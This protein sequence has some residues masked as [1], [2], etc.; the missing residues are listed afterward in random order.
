MRDEQDRLSRARGE[1]ES[2]LGARQRFVGTYRGHLRNLEQVANDLLSAYRSANIETREDP[3]PRHFGDRWRID[4][5]PTPVFTDTDVEAVN[6]AVERAKAS[7][8]HQVRKVAE[9][10]SAGMLAFERIEQ[11][12]V[13]ELTRVA[14][15]ESLQAAR[16]A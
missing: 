15:P 12:T 10:Y 4:I 8:E 11:L 2:I 14:S 9:A 1:Y 3:P 13:E 7:L 6:A 16:V 5:P